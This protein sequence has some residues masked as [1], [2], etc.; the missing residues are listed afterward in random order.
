M[1]KL[2]S[3][4]TIG[5]FSHKGWQWAAD[6]PGSG[7]IDIAGV[8]VDGDGVPVDDGQVEAWLPYAQALEADADMPGFRRVATDARGEFRLRLSPAPRAPGEPAAYVTVFARGLTRHQFTV[9]YLDDDLGLAD[10]ALLAPVPAARRPTLIARRTADGH[11][12]W[13][14]RLQSDRETVFFDYT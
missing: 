7:A 8:L 3:S 2:T 4:Q 6:R 1:S 14:I 11:Y 12:R 13:E 5:P 9:V 10:A